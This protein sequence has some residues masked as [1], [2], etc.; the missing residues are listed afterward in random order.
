MI[1]F[2]RAPARA[3]S[4]RDPEVPVLW[5]IHQSVRMTGLAFYNPGAVDAEVTIEII[6]ANGELVGQATRTLEAGK[7]LF[8]THLSAGPRFSRTGVRQKII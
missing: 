4:L 2:L 5:K 3:L 7:R 8:R 1:G 6:A